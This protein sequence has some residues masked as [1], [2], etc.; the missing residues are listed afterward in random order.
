[1]EIN[2]SL[3]NLIRDITLHYVKFYY[4]KYLKDN[5]VS[6]IQEENLV[7]L[8]NDLYDEKQKDLRKYIRKTL[9]D[10]LKENYSSMATENILLEMF[11]DSDLAKER[12]K[13]EILHYQKCSKNK[14]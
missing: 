7:K 5:N 8:L 10:N 2:K 4:E 3:P 1:M 11:K 6:V 9:K 14:Q 13:V 12:V